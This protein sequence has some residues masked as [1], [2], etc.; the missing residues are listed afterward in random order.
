[1]NGAR[2]G[3]LFAPFFSE[4]RAYSS[5]RIATQSFKLSETSIEPAGFIIQK[6]TK[7]GISAVSVVNV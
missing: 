3:Y 6:D 4:A 1:M 2:R 5:S 7:N